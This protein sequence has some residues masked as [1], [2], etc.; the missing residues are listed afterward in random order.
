[1]LYGHCHVI[2]QSN[3]HVRVKFGLNWNQFR[4]ELESS[5]KEKLGHLLSNKDLANEAMVPHF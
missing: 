4:K 3:T 1:M 5:E 2:W